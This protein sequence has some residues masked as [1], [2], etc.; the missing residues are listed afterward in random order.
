MASFLF[1]CSYF[2]HL[3]IFIFLLASK[4]QSE[5]SVSINYIFPFGALP[6]CTMNSHTHTCLH[7]FFLVW[8]SIYI[9]IPPRHNKPHI[10]K[11]NSKSRVRR[12]LANFRN[13]LAYNFKRKKWSGCNIIFL[14]IY[15]SLIAKVDSLLGVIALYGCSVEVTVYTFEGG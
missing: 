4:T 11:R 10:S 6:D 7:F 15:I 3:W 9:S 8:N 14:Y 5:R 13:L 12:S 2:R 1:W